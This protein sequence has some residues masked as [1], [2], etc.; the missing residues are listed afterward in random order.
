[1]KRSIL[2]LLSL[3]I[4]TASAASFGADFTKNTKDVSIEDELAN[5]MTNTANEDKADSTAEALSSSSIQQAIILHAHSS[6]HFSFLI[7]L[8]TVL[9]CILILVITAKKAKWF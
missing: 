9:F 8:N 6:H 5:Y 4:L 7:F 1:M 3:F 2:L